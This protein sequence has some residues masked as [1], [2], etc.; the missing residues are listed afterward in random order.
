MVEVNCET[1]FVARER[2]LSRIRARRGAS[3]ARA[4]RAEPSEALGAARLPAVTSIEERRRALVAKIGENISVRRFVVLSSPGTLG[5][6]VH[7]TRIGALVAL[8]G[9]DEAL[10]ARPGDARRREQPALRRRGR[11]CRRR[12][13]AKEREIL[14]EQAKGERQ[15][16]GDRRQDGRRPA[17]QVPGG[18]HA[19]RPALRQGSGHHRSRSC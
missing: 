9:G 19:A 16:A 18:N 14:T 8:E 5:A 12:C 2:G 15:A 11:R 17:A 3:R 4:A 7:G 1:D 13:V 6:Y 10:A